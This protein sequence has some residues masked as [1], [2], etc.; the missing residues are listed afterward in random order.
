MNYKTITVSL[1]MSLAVIYVWLVVLYSNALADGI[2]TKMESHGRNAAQ[3][4]IT[5]ENT[6]NDQFDQFSSILLEKEDWESK[7]IEAE[8]MLKLI[9]EAQQASI[10]ISS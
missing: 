9:K 2:S 1:T 4:I 10:N 3:Q 6:R 7:L 5:T 8:L